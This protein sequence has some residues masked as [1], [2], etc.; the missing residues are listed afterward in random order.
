MEDDDDF[1]DSPSPEARSRRKKFN[2]LVPALLGRWYWAALGLVLGVLGS[3]YY[4]SKA[5]KFY[6]A[7]TTLAITLPERGMMSGG[8]AQL[9]EFDTSTVEGLNTIAARLGRV[10]LLTRV[11]SRPDVLALRGILPPE[12]DWRPSWWISWA[13]G[14]DAPAPTA[15]DARSLPQTSLVGIIGSGIGVSVR[16][17][18]RLLDIT[19]KHQDPE[20]A[21]VLADAVATEY[22]AETQ[23]IASENRATQSSTLNRQ[24]EESSRKLAETNAALGN[25]ARVLQLHQELEAQ[26]IAYA[27]LA[28]RYRPK[29]PDMVDARGKIE[30]TKRRF[31]AELNMAMNSAADAAYW[32][33][34]AAAIKAAP[35]QETQLTAARQALLSRVSVLN[36]EA[37]SQETI[38]QAM[39]TSS[40]M[41]NVDRD[42][43]EIS[44][45]VDSKA[46]LPGMPSEPS[47]PKVMVAGSAGGL[48]LG[49][50]LAF[51]LV[52]LDNKFHSVAE[53]EAETD[54][55]ILAAVAQI[56]P[57]HLAQA[58]K[59]AHKRGK[60]VEPDPLQE[61]WDP[62]LLFRPG[63]SNTN[64]CETFRALRASVSLLGDENR[65]R[66][67]LFTSS[68]PGEGKSMVSANFALASAAQGRKTLLIDLDLRKPRQHKV[69][70][71]PRK[72]EG[73][74]GST[75]WCARQCTMEEAII[76][77][78]GAENLH[79]I[80]SGTRAPNPGE[81]LQADRLREMFEEAMAK[82]DV[83]V[84]D[85]APLLAVPDT[86]IIATLAHNICLIVRA[87]WVPKGAVTRSLELL[88]IAGTPPSGL[89]LNG[90]TESRRRIGH[91]YSYGSY[92]MSRYGKAY[93]YGYGSYG[94]YGSYGHDDDEGEEETA[95]HPKGKKKPGSKPRV[96]S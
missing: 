2:H 11:A 4:L 78:T 94:S 27:T 87:D 70:G 96:S 20:V 80:L 36:A 66:V 48:F 52:K 58:I 68:L 69:F 17:K 37:K 83:V 73:K 53:L 67:T 30:D 26:E 12:V 57:S 41:G 42:T 29:Y 72:Q 85:S 91:N 33:T 45:R 6:T 61:N 64:F 23:Q 88:E 21:R 47:P 34:A 32:Q 3:L 95:D 81:L 24:S 59:T 86:R 49:L 76:T 77:E 16:P 15:T 46:Q 82:Y 75:E 38:L 31:L 79:I 60:A 25:Y 93:Q 63:L 10:E 74:G 18:T 50:A 8:R 51:L 90:F 39:S 62:F 55:P 35:D 84:I 40:T 5:P 92:R 71:F 44:I 19:F 43:S 56:N 65:R 1:E 22:V 13:E 7:T 54:V 9:E 89:I 14:P 28:L